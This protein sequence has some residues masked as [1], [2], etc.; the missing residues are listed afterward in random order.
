MRHHIG[1][2]NA[3]AHRRAEVT[4]ETADPD[5]GIFDRDAHGELTGVLREAALTAVRTAMPEPDEAA[6]MAALEAGGR[7]FLRAG[8]TSAVEAGIYD[9]RELRAYQRLREQGRL[10]FRAY[11][12]MIID[13]TLDDLISLG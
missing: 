12:M 6:M 8:V 5:G 10:P 2:A 1:A 4:R 9:P 11:L 7:E 13:E 3:M